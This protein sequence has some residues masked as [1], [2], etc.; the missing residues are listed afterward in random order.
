MSREVSQS[1]A[2]D[3]RFGLGRV[4][5]AFAFTWITLGIGM[6]QGLASFSLKGNPTHQTLA[7]MF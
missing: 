5:A 2:T 7:L 4:V 3:A 6:A 1:A